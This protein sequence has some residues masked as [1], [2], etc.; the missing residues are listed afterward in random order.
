MI[1]DGLKKYPGI[2]R[3]GQVNKCLEKG[4]EGNLRR[5]RFSEEGK[6]ETTD[7]NRNTSKDASLEINLIW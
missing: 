4:E 1:K 2:Q 7:N 6:G 3:I 5:F